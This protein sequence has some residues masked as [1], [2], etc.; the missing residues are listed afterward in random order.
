MYQ[1]QQTQAAL[2][3]LSHLSV[4]KISATICR[5]T[6]KIYFN[7]D[8][9]DLP[10][11]VQLLIFQ[12]IIRNCVLYDK[13]HWDDTVNAGATNMVSFEIKMLWY[14][15]NTI[16]RC[17][18]GNVAVPISIMRSLWKASETYMKCKVQ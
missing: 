8:S 1:K 10:V 12:N 16:I 4:Y 2:V 3:Q 9:K 15:T 5:P 14:Q 13:V 18:Q 7:T 17:L 6:Y 11:I